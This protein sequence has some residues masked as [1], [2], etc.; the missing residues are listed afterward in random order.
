MFLSL[1]HV[2]LLLSVYINRCVQS[3]HATYDSKSS[4]LF[5]YCQ[6]PYKGYASTDFASAQNFSGLW[7][8]YVQFRSSTPSKNGTFLLTRSK[9]IPDPNTTTRILVHACLICTR[10]T[11]GRV[12]QERRISIMS[13]RSS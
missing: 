2:L 4:F 13:A 10:R 1:I 9:I 3:I 8:S 12:L 7:T 11:L 6:I 5:S